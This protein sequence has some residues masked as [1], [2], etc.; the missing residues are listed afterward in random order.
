MPEMTLQDWMDRGTKTGRKATV[1]ATP[2]PTPE[3]APE[4]KTNPWTT[5]PDSAWAAEWSMAAFGAGRIELGYQLAR[6]SKHA[7]RYERQ[8]AAENEGRHYRAPQP[9]PKD[10]DEL[11][12]V[13]MLLERAQHVAAELAAESVPDP[14][15]YPYAVVAGKA[16]AAPAVTPSGRC[17][18]R[19]H[20]NRECHGVAFLDPDRDTWTH[21]DT[22]LDQ[23]HNPVVPGGR[24]LYAVEPGETGRIEQQS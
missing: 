23:F 9:P 11:P 15:S 2:E 12:E 6:L 20:T 18:A 24:S 3:P 14:G 21:L 8:L 13:G 16:T 7:Y 10:E 22:T 17:I 1:T 5:A 4:P 19:D